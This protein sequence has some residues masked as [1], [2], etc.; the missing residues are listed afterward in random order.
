MAYFVGE[1]T[2]KG[3]GVIC[4]KS[5][6]LATSDWTEFVH[7]TLVPW[8]QFSSVLYHSAI[9]FPSHVHHRRNTSSISY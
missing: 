9:Q 3:A 2:G 7:F 8:F 5:H 4:D 6:S 1:E